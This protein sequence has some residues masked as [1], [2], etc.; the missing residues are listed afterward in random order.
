MLEKQSGQMFSIINQLTPLWLQTHIVIYNLVSFY[1]LQSWFFP[2]GGNSNTSFIKLPY[3]MEES[4][5][6][7]WLGIFLGIHSK[8]VIYLL[9]LFCSA[10]SNPLR[11]LSFPSFVHHYIKCNCEWFH[12][13]FTIIHVHPL[14]AKCQI[15][16]SFF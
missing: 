4:N 10:G 15:C 12:A 11:S 14:I 3:R 2:T 8:Y 16:F 6:M 9:L 1:L 13:N 7:L 5:W